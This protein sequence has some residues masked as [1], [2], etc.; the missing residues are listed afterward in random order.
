MRFP[1]QI[2]VIHR[3]ALG[4]LCCILGTAMV[5]VLPA[6]TKTILEEVL[7]PSQLAIELRLISNDSVVDYAAIARA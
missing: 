2:T 4:T 3:L 7:V 5:L 6:V 1:L